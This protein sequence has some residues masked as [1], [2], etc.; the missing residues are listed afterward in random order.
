[1]PGLTSVV[2]EWLSP[3]PTYGLS[4]YTAEYYQHILV[5]VW[6]V[7]KAFGLA[8]LLGVGFGLLLGWSRAFKEYVFPLFEM[9]RPIPILASVPLAIVTF[10]ATESAGVSLGVFLAVLPT[11]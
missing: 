10:T 2:K 3:A 4:I 11:A 1:M 9:L 7:T 6:R 5:S 8:T